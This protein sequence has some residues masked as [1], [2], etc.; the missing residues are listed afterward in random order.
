[1]AVAVA[2]NPVVPPDSWQPQLDGVGLLDITVG[3]EPIGGVDRLRIFSGYSGWIAGQL[4]ME[5]T[6]GS[7]FVLDAEAGDVF[8][9]DPTGLWTAVLRRQPGRL[10]FYA[11]FPDVL[12]EN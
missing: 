12:S 4:E 1:V 8:C 5:L 9:A 2:Q 10:A 6:G 7:W 11:S 3:P